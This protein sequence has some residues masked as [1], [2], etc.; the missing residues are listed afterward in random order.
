MSQAHFARSRFAL[1]AAE[2]LE[3]AHQMGVVH[4]DIKPAN[5]LV[6]RAATFGSPISVSLTVTNAGLTMTGD[7]MGTFRTSRPEQALPAAA[8]SI[9]AP[10][11][12]PWA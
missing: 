3:Y 1:Q 6:D 8:P 10:I 11:S 4:R 12:T 5:L 9:I 7:V 2:A